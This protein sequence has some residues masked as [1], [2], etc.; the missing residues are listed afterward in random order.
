MKKNKNRRCSSY[1]LFLAISFQWT[2]FTPPNIVSI[3][4]LNSHRIGEVF[5]RDVMVVYHLSTTYLYP[6]LTSH[7]NALQKP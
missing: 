5:I 4:D 6:W 1:H 2:R 7:Y 3:E